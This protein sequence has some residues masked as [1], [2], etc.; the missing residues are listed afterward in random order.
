MAQASP[1]AHFINTLTLMRKDAED[2]DL[3]GCETVLAFIS[4]KEETDKPVKITDL[5]QSLM[6]G[7]G[8]TV[9]RRVSLLAE[10]G[11]IKIA[12]SKDDARAKHLTLTKSGIR[13]MNERS[14]L[15]AETLASTS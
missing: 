6:L 4:V 15:M 2:R 13:L 14:K 8:P 1:Y 12:P 10:R 9:Q 11:L 5:I 3:E 7:T